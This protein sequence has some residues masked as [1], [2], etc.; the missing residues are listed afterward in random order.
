MSQAVKDYWISKLLR[1]PS[2]KYSHQLKEVEETGQPF[3]KYGSKQILPMWIQQQWP[4]RAVRE[5]NTNETCSHH[6]KL[7]N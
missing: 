1:L 6:Q 4:L 7:G 5:E 2:S 3:P